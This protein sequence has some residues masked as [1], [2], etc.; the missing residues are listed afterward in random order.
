VEQSD[1][2]QLT[3]MCSREFRT[4][5]SEYFW[6]KLVKAVKLNSEPGF[7]SGPGDSADADSM[8]PCL[9]VPV[10]PGRLCRRRL[11]GT[12]SVSYYIQ[13]PLG[14]GLRK[15]FSC[16]ENAGSEHRRQMDTEIR[17]TD[18]PM[19]LDPTYHYHLVPCDIK[20]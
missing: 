20:R 4:K 12:L 3:I 9:L 8:A 6:T 18:D 17:D 16:S 2:L 5:N 19:I 13:S 7:Q 1:K 11:D 15:V 10:R 14:E